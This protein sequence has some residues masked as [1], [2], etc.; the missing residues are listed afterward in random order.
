MSLSE[1][2]AKNVLCFCLNMFYSRMHPDQ[3]RV[4]GVAPG[5][6]TCHP[7]SLMGHPRCQRENGFHSPHV[8]CLEAETQDA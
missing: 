8:V 7:W 2:K 3:W 1:L 6:G 4:W 5:D